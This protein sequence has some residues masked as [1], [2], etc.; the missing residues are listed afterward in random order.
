MSGSKK[1]LL[2]VL[3]AGALLA[4]PLSGCG[5]G[6]GGG[7]TTD[8]VPDNQ[9]DDDGVTEPGDGGGV[10]IEWGPRLAGSGLSALSGGNDGF[11]P[12]AGLAAAA[13]AAPAVAV[14]GVSQA[15]LA[16]LAVD[17]MRVQV[18]R[19][20]DGNVVYELTDDGQIVVWVPSPLPRLGY[21]VA[22]FSDLIPG[23]EPDLTSYP[24]EV[25]GM[26]E[27][28]DAAGAFWSRSPSVPP[29]EFGAASPTGTATYEGDAVGLHA[30]GGSA[31]KFLADVEMVADF[32][33]RTV[34]GEVEGFRSLAGT[35]LGDLSVTLGET[36]FSPEGGPFS[37]VTSGEAGSVD[38]DGSGTWGGRWSDGEGWTMGGTFGFAADDES[39]S[40]LGAFT[41]C[42]CASAGG[43]DPNDPVATPQ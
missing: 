41:A 32:D 6:G 15:S 31:S 3:A 43:G 1:H 14:N 20:D 40:V 11:G 13:R 22:V 12:V 7:P 9:P 39:T 19:D 8:G 23:I 17:A 29:V 16:G 33:D 5:G 10:S 42:S 30:S 27:L 28:G 34:G 38:I 25:M 21:S 24:H 4:L 36:G 35:S 37:G 2:V 26:W 18:G